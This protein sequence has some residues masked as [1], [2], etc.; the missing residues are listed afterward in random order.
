MLVA[1][2]SLSVVNLHEKYN[3]ANK[4]KQSKMQINIIK[5]ICRTFYRVCYTLENIPV[6]NRRNVTQGFN[7]K[8]YVVS[9]RV[10]PPLQRTF[11][12]RVL[13]GSF[14]FWNIF[15]KRGEKEETP[16]DKLI[17]TIKRSI[18]CVQRGELNKA[19]QMLHLALRMAQ[20]LQSKDGYDLTLI[21]GK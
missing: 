8:S 16:E 5:S 12:G 4:I 9:R 21:P 20:D 7:G 14:Y 6:H 15:K 2:I 1:L 3:F 10:A 11:T 17:M 13:L 19:E 18:L